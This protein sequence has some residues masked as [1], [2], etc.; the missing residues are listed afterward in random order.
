MSRHASGG[1]ETALAEGLLTLVLLIAAGIGI[2]LWAMLSEL[3]N[4][5][6]TRAFTG[7]RSAKVLWYALACLLGIFLL[8]GLLATQ[9]HMAPIGLFTACW[10]LFAYVIVCIGI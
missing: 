10:S 9:P 3:W 5:Y 7:T 1:G 4:I 8:A 6:K 2:L